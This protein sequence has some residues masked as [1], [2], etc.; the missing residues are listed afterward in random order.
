MYYNI[1]MDEIILTNMCLLKFKDKFL[2]QIRHKQDWPGLTL[3]GGKV[4]KDETVVDSVYREFKEET[5]LCLKGVEF[6]DYIEWNIASKRH[7]CLLFKSDSFEGTLKDSLEG[8]NVWLTLK[9]ARKE[10]FSSDFD[11]ILDLYKVDWR[12][13]DD[14]RQD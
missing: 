8:K 13:E 4:E 9:E 2:F 12:K 10:P 11:K 7:L 6:V 3:P 14:Q 1:L 5:G